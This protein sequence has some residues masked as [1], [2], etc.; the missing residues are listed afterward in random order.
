M[1][2]AIEMTQRLYPGLLEH[3]QNLLFMLKCRQFV[4]MVNGT[5]SDPFPRRCPPPGIGSYSPS[6]C[7]SPRPTSPIQTSVIQSTKNYSNKTKHTVEEINNQNNVA[8]NG[9]STADLPVIRTEEDSDVDM[10]T[11]EEIQNGH[12]N[13]VKCLSQSPPQTTNGYQNGNSHSVFTDNYQK[14]EDDD[15]D[16][17]KANYRPAIARD[18]FRFCCRCRYSA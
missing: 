3:N 11:S 10:E 1:G 13:K 18:S 8:V 2:E 12:G 14:D 6:Y 16:M 17:G 15:E 5:D 9:N 7:T 4:E